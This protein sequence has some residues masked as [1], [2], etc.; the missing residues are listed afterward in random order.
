[1]DVTQ[2]VATRHDVGA[3]T[4]DMTAKIERLI[5]WTGVQPGR[6]FATER[7]MGSAADGAHLLEGKRVVGPAPVAEQWR[8]PCGPPVPLF[9]RRRHARPFAAPAVV[10]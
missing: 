10:P 1:M 9:L 7:Q 6:R 5:G 4:A 3:Q 8:L 2:L